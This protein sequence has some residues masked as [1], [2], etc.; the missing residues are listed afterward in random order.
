MLIASSKYLAI[1]H[2]QSVDYIRLTTN[3]RLK[4]DFFFL[5]LLR[6]SLNSLELKLGIDK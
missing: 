3:K 2:D 1:L 5:N 6:E 4:I